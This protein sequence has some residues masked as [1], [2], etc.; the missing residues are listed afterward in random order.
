MLET[1][2]SNIKVRIKLGLELGSG[3]GIRFVP[4][5]DYY[6]PQNAFEAILL[7]VKASAR[8]LILMS[9]S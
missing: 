4:E 3:L 9:N 1:E 8:V 7:P 2:T 6:L 5:N